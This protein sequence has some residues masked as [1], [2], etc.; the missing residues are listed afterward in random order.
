MNRLFFFIPLIIN[1]FLY[2]YW[3]ISKDIIGG[4]WPYFWSDLLREFSFFVPSWMSYQI[5]GFGGTTV[6]YA[7]D[8]YLYAVSYIFTTMLSLPWQ[9]VY[10][11][12]FFGMFIALA[13]GSSRSFLSKLLAGAAWWQ[14]DIASIVY[15][16]NTFILMIVGGGQMGVALALAS[17][18]LALGFAIAFVNSIHESKPREYIRQLIPVGLL[19]AL[20]TLFDVRIAFLVIVAQ[21]FYILVV[22]FRSPG[23]LVISVIVSM[24]PVIAIT[25]LLHAVWI[26]PM[27]IYRF[28]P[29]TY[30]LT[31]SSGAGSFI[32]YSFASFSNALSVLHPNW[33]ENVFGKV[34]FF[35]PE[36]LFIPLIAFAGFL[37]I[38]SERLNS[39]RRIILYCGLLAMIGVF[40]SKGA[41]EPLGEVNT[42]LYLFMPGFSVFRDPTKFYLYVLLGYLVLIPSGLAYIASFITKYLARGKT[43]I[44]LGAVLLCF[45]LIWG[46]TIRDAIA[47]NLGGTFLPSKVPNEYVTLSAMISPQQNF[48][49]T[50]W[51]P[52]QQRFTYYTNLHPA[53]EANHFFQA[54]NSA[55]LAD[56]VSSPDAQEK[57]QSAAI[58]YVIVP[59]DSVGEIFTEDRRYDDTKWQD[60]VS[61]LDGIAWLER[62]QSI[63][64]LTVYEVKNPSGRFNLKR[65][66]KQD[67][68]AVSY[69]ARSTTQYAVEVSGP[70]NLVFSEN[71]NPSWKA[72]MGSVTLPSQRSE[73]GYNSFLIPETGPLT[74]RIYFDQ[75]NVYTYGRW[76][77]I[78]TLMVMVGLWLLVRRKSR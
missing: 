73:L 7:L 75:E 53:V 64:K 43:N 12:A 54:T 6:T 39:N 15:T 41:Q 60:A 19:Y 8:S 59:Y 4:D 68:E 66:E 56:K 37:G 29:Y 50:L 25:A 34:S 40:L 18:P 5:N 36:F 46:W 76:I 72:K 3:L 62:K 45:I 28:S 70:G 32:F 9:A 16:T 20:I 44:A 42:W 23:R 49:R 47:G 74:A 21:A 71:Y 58:K 69:S 14:R 26:L 30:V 77:S 57:V 10:K 24:A 35:R 13:Y 33:P 51:Y 63:G 52:R 67:G 38:G 22:S 65:G 17:A 78:V 27:V 1:V 55:E 61:V 11:G 48:F 31:K 2:R